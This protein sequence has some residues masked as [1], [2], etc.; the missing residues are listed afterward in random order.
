[1]TSLRETPEH[2]DTLSDTIDTSALHCGPKPPL[3]LPHF[4]VQCLLRPSVRPLGGRRVPNIVSTPV[5]C[6]A[7]RWVS[8]NC[9]QRSHHSQILLNVS[10]SQDTRQCSNSCCC[11]ALTR[12]LNSEDEPENAAKKKSRKKAHHHQT[13]SQ[14]R[15][16]VGIIMYRFPNAGSATRPRAKHR[17]STFSILRENR[18][19]Y[20]TESTST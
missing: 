1:M 12:G 2:R 4:D 10:V 8:V 9:E 14:P 6:S 19:T 18:E 17:L 7:C 16:D 5:T 3:R 13:T 11:Y 20:L 15:I